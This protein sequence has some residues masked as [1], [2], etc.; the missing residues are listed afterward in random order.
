[1]DHREHWFLCNYSDPATHTSDAFLA[2][3]L[4]TGKILWT[5]NFQ[6]SKGL[7]VQIVSSRDGQTVAESQGLT[8]T[9]FGLDAEP[10]PVSAA[11]ADVETPGDDEGAVLPLL[12]KR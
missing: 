9:L 6:E 3:D 7:P 8:S 11:E 2:M 12:R 4:N 5:H 10:Q 1:M